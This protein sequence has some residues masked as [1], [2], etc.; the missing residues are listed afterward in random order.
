MLFKK[1]MKTIFPPR[2]MGVDTMGEEEIHTL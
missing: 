1:N 2:N